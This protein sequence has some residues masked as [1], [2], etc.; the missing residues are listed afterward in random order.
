MLLFNMISARPINSNTTIAV[1]NN[2]EIE[3]ST[4]N[5]PVSDSENPPSYESV[6]NPSI[7]VP[8]QISTNNDLN[9]LQ[10]DSSRRFRSFN[11][12]WRV[13]NINI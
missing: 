2:N 7:S 11:N 6:I 9:N 1:L 4:N 3:L 13:Y 5:H 8:V 12:G 10:S